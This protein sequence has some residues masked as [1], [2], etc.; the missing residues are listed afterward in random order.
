RNRTI[1]DVRR[2]GKYLWFALDDDAALV[3]HLGMSGQF[4]VDAGPHA[5]RTEP[6]QAGSGHQS[7]GSGRQPT[8]AGH[9]H[10]R[11]TF[12]LDETARSDARSGGAGILRFVD[13]RT[14]GAMWVSPGDAA[15]PT[16]IAH[17]G[18]DLFDPE[19]DLEEAAQRMRRRRSTVKR[20]M[21]DQ[22]LVSGIGNIYADESLWRARLHPLTPTNA[23]S[24]R[25]AVELWQV[26]RGVMV[27]ALEQ[28]GTSF[29]KLYVNVNGSSGYFGRS[30]DVYGRE[31]EPCHR[32][33]TP[34]V[35]ESFM[36]RS[37]HL[38]PGCQQLR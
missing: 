22:S 16:E 15:L 5:V 20:A 26:A 18:R 11:A 17:I 4:R 9:R 19:I 12:L 1:V 37:S 14:F 7:A 38:C 28:G 2:R 30:L 31:G 35:R 24:Q 8:D 29:D 3:A 25:Q 23:M 13:Q 21:L 33:G 32:C 36:N 10:T 6:L 34:I 27:E